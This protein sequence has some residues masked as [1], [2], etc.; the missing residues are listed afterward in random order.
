[1]SGLVAA[2][3]MMCV[4]VWA[5]TAAAAQDN[6]SMSS[7]PGQDMDRGVKTSSADQKFMMMAAT[8]GMA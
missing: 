4:C 3:A 8:G 6:K 1:M 7:G 2:A 5:Q